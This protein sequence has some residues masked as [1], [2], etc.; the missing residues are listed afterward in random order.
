[1]ACVHNVIIRGLNSIYLQA[2]NVAPTKVSA[3]TP[4]NKADVQTRDDFVDYAREWSIFLHLHHD[5][6]E[7]LLFPEIEKATATTGIMDRNVQ[8]H[9]LFDEG[10]KRFD[11]YLARVRCPVDGKERIGEDKFLY[12]PELAEIIESFGST[13]TNHLN[14]EI[15]TLL[16]LRVYGGTVNIEKLISDV[17]E[18]ALKTASMIG[19]IPFCFHNLDNAFEGGLHKKTFPPAP[20]LIMFLAKWILWIPNRRLWRF[21]P[22]NS[23]RNLRPKLLFADPK[24]HQN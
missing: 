9:R 16:S 14:E 17:G 11:D 5:G 12:G 24:Q 8:Q 2:R 6:E 21:A 13:L 10:V 1:M 18:H 23:A 22:A 20:W 4:Q 15:G 3:I 19:T 7:A